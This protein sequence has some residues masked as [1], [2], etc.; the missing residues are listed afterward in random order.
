MSG[1]RLRTFFS[2]RKDSLN[3]GRHGLLGY[4]V[5]RSDT[6]NQKVKIQSFERNCED[7]RSVTEA[8]ATVC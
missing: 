2:R 7:W 6:R 8:M 1:E 3:V 5:E 4:H